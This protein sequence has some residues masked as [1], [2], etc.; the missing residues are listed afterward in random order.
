ME[1]PSSRNIFVKFREAP[2][3]KKVG[4]TGIY[5]GLTPS[6]EVLCHFFIEFRE[7]PDELKHIVQDGNLVPE[8]GNSPTPTFIRELQVGVLVSA[9]VV[10]AIG[11]WFITQSNTIEQMAQGKNPG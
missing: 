7:I 8:E 1:N 3:Y 10:R 11:E 5:G 2:D 9:Q 4:A 6:G